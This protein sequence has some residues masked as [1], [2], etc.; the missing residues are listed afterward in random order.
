[1]NTLRWLSTALLLA[2]LCMI[3]IGIQ[4]LA[5]SDPT[6]LVPP[7]PESDS[8]SEGDGPQQFS[9]TL[10]TCAGSAI[11]VSDLPGVPTLSNLVVTDTG[12]TG[13]GRLANN[14]DG[15]LTLTAV[16]SGVFTVT[17]EG[18]DSGGDRV[19]VELRV[20]IMECILGLGNPAGGNAPNTPQALGNVGLECGETKTVRIWFRFDNV[21][22]INTFPMD[23][24]SIAGVDPSVA[25]VSSNGETIQVT[26]T[27][28]GSLEL[29][30]EVRALSLGAGP[31]TDV[32][33]VSLG[34]TVTNDCPEPPEKEMPMGEEPGDQDKPADNVRL[35]KKT[36]VMPP[37]DDGLAPIFVGSRNILF[38]ADPL[39]DPDANLADFN[40]IQKL[41]LKEAVDAL[42]Q[43]DPKV[44][45]H[46]DSSTYPNF[47]K[48][49]GS[50]LNV[51]VTVVGKKTD[52]I[53][54]SQEFVSYKN[55]K[56]PVTSKPFVFFWLWINY[57]ECTPNK[58]AAPEVGV[59]GPDTGLSG[60]TLTFFTEAHARGITPEGKDNT[61]STITIDF[62]DGTRLP[63][64]FGADRDV[65]FLFEHTYVNS[66]FYTI[67]VTATDHFGNGSEASHKVTIKRPKITFSDTTG[68]VATKFSGIR[69]S[70]TDQ[71][72]FSYLDIVELDS[73]IR[74]ADTVSNLTFPPTN[75]GQLVGS[76][77]RKEPT[78]PVNTEQ[79]SL[80]SLDIELSLRGSIPQSIDSDLTVYIFIIDVDGDLDTGPVDSL[81]P[82][83][84]GDFSVSIF[85]ASPNSGAF[86]GLSV[87]D[88][89]S[90]K[91]EKFDELVTFSFEQDR[92]LIRATVDLDRL[93]KNL[94]QIGNVGF[95][96]DTYKLAVFSWELNGR[97][98]SNLP[99]PRDEGIADF[100]P[101]FR[102][103]PQAS[104]FTEVPPLSESSTLKVPD[105]F[106]TIDG[107]ILA[108]TPGNTIVVG[109]GT[110]RG[111]FFIDIPLTFKAERPG[112][113][114]L[115]GT[116]DGALTIGAD[117]VIVEGIAVT[118]AGTGVFIVDANNVVLDNVTVQRNA[119]T[120][121][122]ID[123]S[124][125]V[126]VKNSTVSDHAFQGVFVSNST[127]VVFE[128]NT[129]SNN[130][131]AAL[132]VRGST[133]T[134][135]SNH[136]TG[137]RLDPSKQFAEGIVVVDGKA[138]I[139]G[140]QITNNQGVGI[141]V[142]N[143][144]AVINDNTINN[145]RSCGVFGQSST[146][147]GN[148]N[149]FSNNRG[150]DRCGDVP[151]GL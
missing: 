14:E 133:T 64:T 106:A 143:A 45:D 141:V 139:T 92:T 65:R 150:G 129:L 146:V 115:K 34:I 62:G 98:N 10:S 112:T 126:T 69:V 125:R 50:S 104:E 136:I 18:D 84:G 17:L 110:Y 119:K 72:T 21:V 149:R 78:E 113:V 148:G 138:T 107:A 15:K 47:F 9:F 58:P 23:V 91:F 82:D 19:V 36:G 111:D 12:G 103:Q 75:R 151:P 85:P 147:S 108:A 11:N 74:I 135:R 109:P 99:A 93:N 44:F 52:R 4:T 145:N 117:D 95:N 13:L 88:P 76:N 105:N 70:Q 5:Q 6:V 123:S 39:L 35:V 81:F 42:N 43:I 48:S 20:V 120:G 121:I 89:Q 53:S 40:R 80:G 100:A 97:F 59:S 28:K 114:T 140:N 56:A 102:Y 54:I 90:R 67:T 29:M 86:A 131:V 79:T 94:Q 122:F 31:T 7:D 33:K 26:G 25:E 60:E 130:T 55:P 101:E 38:Q 128:N 30:L 71:D 46:N 77:Q 32:I 63:R 51:S 124:N 87:W 22:G 49:F 142:F 96:A 37:C 73:E 116:R 57:Y 3:V 2:S 118:G 134:I 68:D 1:V 144:A 8:P 24:L 61:I 132:D 41:N 16:S 66:G 83:V 127:G 27:G 137:T